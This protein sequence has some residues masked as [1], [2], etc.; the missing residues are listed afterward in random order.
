MY[1]GFLL[2]PH[3]RLPKMTKDMIYLV[4][5]TSNHSDK[6]KALVLN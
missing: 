6:L 4:V 5:A 3:T 1:M 2:L